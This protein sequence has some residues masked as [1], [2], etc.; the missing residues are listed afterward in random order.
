MPIFEKTEDTT[1]LDIV[2]LE[3]IIRAITGKKLIS[4]QYATNKGVHLVP[5]KLHG[6]PYFNGF[7]YL[8]GNE[9]D[10]GLLKR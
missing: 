7:W 4:F 3:K 9:T 2:L 8:I 10:T 6:V 1:L 5:M